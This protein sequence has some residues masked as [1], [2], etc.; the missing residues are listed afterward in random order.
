MGEAKIINSK[1]QVIDDKELLKVIA[2]ELKDEEVINE[3]KLQEMLNE[4]T[5]GNDRAGN[6][7]SNQSCNCKGG[8]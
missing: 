1:L 6:C 4:N 8:S 3:A 2:R 5:S 7:G